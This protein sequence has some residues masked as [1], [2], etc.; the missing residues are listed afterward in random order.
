MADPE[1]QLVAGR[2][3]SFPDF[4]V[5]GVLFRDI[6]PLL[7]DPDSFRASISLLAD[8]L[9]KTHGGN[10][11]YIVGL[12]SRG[13][14]FGPSLAQELGLGCV[15]I[16][17]RGK[18]PG[19]TVSASYTLEYGKAE[20]EI[21]RDALEPGQKVV[22]VDDLL[23]TGGTMRAACELLG[24]LQAEVLECVSLVELTSLKGREKLTP[25]PFFS[26]LQFE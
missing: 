13:F 16:R 23:A 21:Q 7:K 19:P 6:S 26:L 15:L 3:R 8:H 4:P 20:L 25:V 5:P 12:D 10:I 9:K 17:K 14:L 24:Q 2:I 18:L 1:L 22:V 11:D